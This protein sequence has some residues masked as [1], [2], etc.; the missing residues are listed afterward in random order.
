[1]QLLVKMRLYLLHTKPSFFLH[2]QTKQQLSILVICNNK[3][4]FSVFCRNEKIAIGAM[5]D[6]MSARIYLDARIQGNSHAH[7]ING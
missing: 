6:G 4:V 7:S 1:M 2:P 5:V 3:D